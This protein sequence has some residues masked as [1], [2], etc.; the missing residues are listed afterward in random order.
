MS[1]RTGRLR[2]FR[3][4]T[5]AVA[6]LVT[7]G[8]CASDPLS[9]SVRR[10]RTDAG[11][12]ETRVSAMLRVAGNTAATGDVA[13]AAG[14]YRRAHDLEPENVTA[15]LG[16]ARSLA[17]LGAND[18]AVAAFRAVLDIDPVQLD[19]LRGLAGI[20][21]AIDQPRNAIDHLEA[22]LEQGEDARIYNALGLAH[23][24]QGDHKAA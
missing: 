20:Y 17:A 15:L 23:D 9:D 8:A 21:I 7:L 5:A 13:T 3:T 24:M 2:M 14:I 6:L 19:A 4:S 12:R 1:N 18:D 16:L 22:A 11:D 10:G